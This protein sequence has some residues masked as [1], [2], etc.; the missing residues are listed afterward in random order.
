[1]TDINLYLY[2]Q[3]M[4]STCPLTGSSV[5]LI[6]TLLLN[7]FFWHK[8]TLMT[9]K[10]LSVLTDMVDVCNKLY[11]FIESKTYGDNSEGDGFWSGATRSHTNTI[12]QGTKLCRHRP[13]GAKNEGLP[14]CVKWKQ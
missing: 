8:L 10:L 3:L 12:L 11:N 2:N 13:C 6:S 7:G 4:I 14:T 5:S 9:R 1:M